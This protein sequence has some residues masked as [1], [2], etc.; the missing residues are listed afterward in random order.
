MRIITFDNLFSKTKGICK[1]LKITVPSREA[2]YETA[3]AVAYD[4]LSFVA[5]NNTSKILR[6]R[7]FNVASDLHKWAEE[8]VTC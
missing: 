7:A 8:N 5:Y 6:E 1:E 3:E 2:V 4:L